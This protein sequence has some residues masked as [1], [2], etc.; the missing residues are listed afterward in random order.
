MF[1]LPIL[2]FV[3]GSAFGYNVMYPPGEKAFPSQFEAEPGYPVAFLFSVLIAVVSPFVMLSGMKWTTVILLTV[4]ILAFL[5]I[6]VLF[7]ILLGNLK[8]NNGELFH[9]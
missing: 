8:I 5:V 4:V 7:V 2:L 3:A 1:F 6:E 9:Y